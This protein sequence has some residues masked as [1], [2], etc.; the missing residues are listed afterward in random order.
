MSRFALNTRDCPIRKSLL[1]RMSSWF[2]RSPYIVPG[3]TRLT[4]VFAAPPESGR[5]SDG[6]ITALVAM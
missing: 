3:V 1:N 5:P 2:K 4:V 6:M